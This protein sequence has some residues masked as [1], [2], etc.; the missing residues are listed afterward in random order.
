MKTVQ[1]LAVGFVMLIIVELLVVPEVEAWG[2]RRR[3]WSSRRR[4]LA[5]R[6]R[7]SSRRRRS[8]LGRAVRAV[9]SAVS[10]AAKTVGRVVHKAVT[11]KIGGYII[12]GVS[13]VN[14]IVGNAC[15]ATAVTPITA[16]CCVVTRG[17]A[18]VN[19]GLQTYRTANFVKE[20]KAKDA[21][22][23]GVGAASSCFQAV[24]GFTPLN[25]VTKLYKAHKAAKA[26]KLAEAASRGRRAAEAET[27]SSP[28]TGR[29]V[30]CGS[31]FFPADIARIKL[32]VCTI[33]ELRTTCS[34]NKATRK[35]SSVPLI[36]QLIR[37]VKTF[38]GQ[39]AFAVRQK[40]LYDL[41]SKTTCAK[42]DVL[43]I[44]NPSKMELKKEF[45]GLE[46]ANRGF[47][48][49]TQV[50]RYINP[51]EKALSEKTCSA[52]LKYAMGHLMEVFNKVVIDVVKMYPNEFKTK[53]AKNIQSDNPIVVPGPVSLKP[54]A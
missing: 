48:P 26:A 13:F 17:I 18:G 51:K 39:V 37:R 38:L 15:C 53:L 50:C 33:M 7:Y 12:S 3:R 25:K 47:D 29:P 43:P 30:K 54:K 24:T 32:T 41:L 49:M 6:R 45:K 40:A 16:G 20:K 46:G 36:S 42:V 10:K 14:G 22:L 1:W 2:R 52:R 8:W 28:S 19:C 21:A 23:G 31:A 4:W 11:S 34:K 9:G 27:S 5:R 44:C 35:G